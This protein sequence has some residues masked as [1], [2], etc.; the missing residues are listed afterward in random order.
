MRDE[1]FLPSIVRPEIAIHSCPV[2]R[3]PLDVQRGSFV[4]LGGG[5]DE[6]E[7]ELVL[8]VLAN[9]VMLSLTF[10]NFDNEAS[11][12]K[13]VRFSPGTPATIEDLVDV[14]PSSSKSSDELSSCTR[15][16]QSHGILIVVQELAIGC[17]FP[18]S[19]PAM[20]TI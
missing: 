3:P 16:N 13:E 6:A 10:G 14:R 19:L 20:C 1:S 8:P 9:L 7:L 15:F 5:S 4:H 17:E 18:I 12:S 2:L 11:L